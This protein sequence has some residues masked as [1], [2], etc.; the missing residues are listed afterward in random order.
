MRGGID[1]AS[2]FEFRRTEQAEA[3]WR[4]RDVSLRKDRPVMDPAD[5]FG[6]NF[7]AES[8]GEVIG[9]IRLN[10]VNRFVPTAWI[11]GSR[12]SSIATAAFYAAGV[13]SRVA[14]RSDWRDT[15]VL[16]NLALTAANL[17]RKR[18]IRWV[19]CSIGMLREIG[20]EH[21][22]ISFFRAMGF[23]IWQHEPEIPGDGH[24]TA[25]LLDIEEAAADPDRVAGLRLYERSFSQTP[26]RPAA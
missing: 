13:I 10:W 23:R 18:R 7:V 3:N 26:P 25:L 2:L 21:R 5:Y 9:S 17:T 6:A 15:P 8:A 19:F 20:E 12:L 11:T 1:L 14:V 16:A 24:G 4:L 22:F